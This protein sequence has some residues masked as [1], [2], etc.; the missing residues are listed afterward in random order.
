MQ[1]IIKIHAMLQCGDNNTIISCSTICLLFPHCD[2][3]LRGV[4]GR[5]C[6]PQ[7]VYNI[8]YVNV[9]GVHSSTPH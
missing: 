7:F 1:N 5:R 2:C 9:C 8:A 4:D 3:C 6:R